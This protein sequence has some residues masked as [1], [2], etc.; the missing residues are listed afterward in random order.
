MDWNQILG[1][2]LLAAGLVLAGLGAVLLLGGRLP[3]LG[4]LPG[5]IHVERE[6][7]RPWFP[8]SSSLLVSALLSLLVYV[9]SRFTR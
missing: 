4:R 1:R 9:V 5:D 7:F 3:W 6:G 2:V 8:L